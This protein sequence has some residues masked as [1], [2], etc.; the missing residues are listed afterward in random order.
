MFAAAPVSGLI[1]GFAGGLTNGFA[2]IIARFFG[3]NDTERL[4]KA[5]A[6]TYVLSAVIAL[7]LTVISLLTL[8]PL[9]ASLQTPEE[10]IADTESYMGIILLFS[11]RS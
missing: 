7:V 3:A 11:T 1:I 8:H 9:M 5:V 6:L 4:K 10:I 2:V